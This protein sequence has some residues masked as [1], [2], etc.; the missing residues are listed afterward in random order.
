M[1]EYRIELKP[2]EPYYFGGENSMDSNNNKVLKY[3]MKSR[4]LPQQTTL[5]GML[6][7]ELLKVEGY[8]KDDY[9]EFLEY[10]SDNKNDI[11][12]LIGRCNFNGELN[13][14][15]SFGIIKKISP[16]I[17]CDNDNNYFM[18]AP[19]NYYRVEDTHNYKSYELEEF[20]SEGNS[21]RLGSLYNLKNYDSK[22]GLIKDYIQISYHSDIKTF[23][24]TDKLI[25]KDSVFEVVERV[26]I[27]KGKN[28]KT[29]DEAYY[30]RKSYLLK[31]NRSF[32]FF[33]DLELDD[34]ERESFVNLGGNQSMFKLKITKATMDNL[35]QKIVK[36]LSSEKHLTIIGETYLD[37]E[38]IL[39]VEIEHSNKNILKFGIIETIDFRSIKIRK[40]N[41]NI[42]FKKQEKKL[43]LI[44]R[45]SILYTNSKS[46]LGSEIDNY[47]NFKQLGYNYYI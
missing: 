15:Q 3:L 18:P 39:N 17:I 34:F 10:Y 14:M 4:E 47:K 7:K 12:K 9:A 37:I 42:R 1:T 11:D 29:Q 28:G 27:T 33:A 2:I 30:K 26:G 41:K 19:K 8:Y 31:E 38:K 25:K 40:E 45:G 5:L 24:H 46:E 20:N 6:R 22:I 35:F 13:D 21:S 36:P 44:D 16:I 32:V 43:K 23:K